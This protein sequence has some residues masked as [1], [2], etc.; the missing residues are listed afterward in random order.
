MS[1]VQFWDCR[2]RFPGCLFHVG[3]ASIQ[4]KW[5]VKPFRSLC[6]LGQSPPGSGAGSR[7]SSATIGDALSLVDPKRP[8]S[9]FGRM[10]PVLSIAV[11]HSACAESRDN[12][13]SAYNPPQQRRGDAAAVVAILRPLL[14]WHGLGLMDYAHTPMVTSKKRRLSRVKS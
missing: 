11:L 14:C 8:L 6:G 7:P 1:P 4:S 13:I 10:T 3:V 5:G 9:Q 12:P 2:C